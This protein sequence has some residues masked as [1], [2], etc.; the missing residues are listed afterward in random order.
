MPCRRVII[1]AKPRT[2]CRILTVALL[3]TPIA[4]HG[5][6]AAESKP[7]SVVEVL[8]YKFFDACFFASVDSAIE[9]KS[10][11]DVRLSIE[12]KQS[13]G[14]CGC[15]SAALKVLVFAEV[16][17]AIPSDSPLGG[18]RLVQTTPMFSNTL[19]MYTLTLSK[20]RSEPPQHYKIWLS[21]AS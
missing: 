10:K 14:L 16:G 8:R 19:E 7:A 15:K 5:H 20:R 9:T 1:A 11:I 18:K 17:T 4:S 12:H 6:A 21:C 2:F 13:S 3:L